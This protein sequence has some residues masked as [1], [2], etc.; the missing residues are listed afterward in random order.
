MGSFSFADDFGVSSS[1]LVN[2]NLKFLAVSHR[3][4]ENLAAKRGARVQIPPSPRG[5]GVSKD[6]PDRD[7]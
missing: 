7:R 4:G 6:T 5:R 3:S 1:R 2:L